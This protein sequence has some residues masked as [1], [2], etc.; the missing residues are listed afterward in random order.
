MAILLFPETNFVNIVAIT[1]SALVLTELLNIATVIQT[2]NR[3]IVFSECVTLA[4]YVTCIVA[5]KSY[6]DLDFI[7]NG[8]FFLKVLLITACAWLPLHLG[9]KA[10]DYFFPDEGRKVKA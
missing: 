1:L 8:W 7:A 9:T 4:V 10:K 3:W 2:W 6:F 5:L